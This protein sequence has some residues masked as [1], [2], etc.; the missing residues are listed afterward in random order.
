MCH[1]CGCRQIPLIRDYIAEH[2]HVLELGMHAVEQAGRGALDEAQAT[3]AR[4]RA[5]VEEKARTE[6]KLR[7]ANYRAETERLKIARELDDTRQRQAALIASLPLALYVRTA[8]K[9]TGPRQFVGGD[10]KRLTGYLPDI[11]M[12]AAAVCPFPRMRRVLPTSAL[13]CPSL[14]CKAPSDT[15]VASDS[16]LRHS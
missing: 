3:V 1:Y 11:L 5:E 12:A 9:V 8:G 4:M 15:S 13:P 16:L 6:Q 2:E 10:L 14:S 7:D